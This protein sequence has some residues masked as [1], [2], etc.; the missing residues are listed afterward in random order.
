MVEYKDLYKEMLNVENLF[1]KTAFA[2]TNA[3]TEVASESASEI[4]NIIQKF[5]TQIPLII[6]G[7]ILII[8][9]VFL[10]KILRS[11]VENKLAEKGIEEDHKEIQVLSGR[12][13]YSGILTI[14]ITA[15]LKVAGIDI[16]AIIAAGAFGIGFALKDLIMNFLAG[17]MI[18]V[19]KHFTIGDFIQ[20]NGT[21]GK[22]IEIQSR[23]TILRAINGTKVIVPNAEL[24]SKQVVSFTSN[25]LRRFDIVVTIDYKNDIQNALNLALKA[26]LESNGVLL[27]PKPSVSII[28]L[29]DNGVSLKLKA[30]CDSKG[31]WVKIRT[32]VVKKLKHLYDQHG[33]IIPY[34]MRTVIDGK[35]IKFEEKMLSEAIEQ[36][37]PNIVQPNIVQLPTQP[38]PLAQ[39]I[40]LTSQTQQPEQSLKP[41]G[42]Q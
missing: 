39:N 1:L 14:G 11:I 41:L 31:G 13:I 9:S 26:A 3:G 32:R 10:A 12:I 16:T 7:F 8:F 40:N 38:Q 25:P 30:W 5:F 35:D 27:E 37:Q 29:G 42:E 20:V 2:A 23:V 15:G 19:G 22:I 4:A 36:N 24:L 21:L 6:A 34:P 17:I 18:L 33:V 28:E